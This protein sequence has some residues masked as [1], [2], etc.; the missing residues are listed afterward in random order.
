MKDKS[1]IQFSI[2]FGIILFLFHLRRHTA[3]NRQKSL[4]TFPV[5]NEAKKISKLLNVPYRY[6]LAIILTESSGSTE[7]TGTVGE[8]G[9]MQVTE[10]TFNEFKQKFNLNITW[11]EMYAITPNIFVGSLI[12]KEYWKFQNYDL[13]DGI[14]SYNVGTDLKPKDKAT[15]YLNK[16]LN[17]AR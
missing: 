5:L 16:V 9:L 13:F 17:N 2:I 10:R 11:D 12:F 15:Y 7:S 8:K 14:K 1:L 6:I 3:S 4:L